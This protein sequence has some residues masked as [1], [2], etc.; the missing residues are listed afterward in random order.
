MRDP[1]AVLIAE[2][3]AGKPPPADGEV[4]VLRPTDDRLY[5]V[6]AFTGHHVVVA[7]IEPAWVHERL[8]AGDL[9]APLQPSF[10][11][12]LAGATGRRVGSID[13]VMLARAGPGKPELDL[14]PVSG[15][16]H[17]RVARA[18]RYRTDVRV[19]RSGCGIVILG[20]GL[21]GRWEVAVEV[22]PRARGQGV[23][24]SLFA[25]ATHLINGPNG[26]NGPNGAD[27]A[28]WAQVA[29]GNV[30]SVRALLAAGY[31]P[32]CAEV[33]LVRS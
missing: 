24:R 21:A 13:V 20:R 18:R 9:S 27:G 31:R 7:D 3:A 25:A 2:L 30:A 5:G 4:S 26:P 14:R 1:L 8:P 28:V 16:D 11:T 29:P 19:W 33:L 10:L 17:L 6:L 32:A 12:T 22:E 15:L 23:G